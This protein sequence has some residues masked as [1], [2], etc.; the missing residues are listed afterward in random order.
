VALVRTNVPGYLIIFTLMME[1][2][3]SSETSVLARSTRHH[4]P[5][6]VILRG[7]E[8]LGV[9][10]GMVYTDRNTRLHIQEGNFGTPM[11]ISEIKRIF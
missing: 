5:E 4:I 11:R 7:F 3:H 6:D 8:I 1:A 10:P 9:T 2:K